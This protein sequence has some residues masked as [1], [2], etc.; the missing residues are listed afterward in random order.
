M[1]EPMR[2]RYY[3]AFSSVCMSA[4]LIGTA[5][6]FYGIGAMHPAAA[7]GLLFLNPLFFAILLASTRLRPAILAMMIGVPLGPVM[8][9]VSADWG[10]L[11]TGFI[12]GTVAFFINR[13][14]PETS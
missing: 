8:H 5:I 2:L 1:T 6:G 3:L 13:R 14:L 4:G 9:L 11:A 10:L 12:G 7:L